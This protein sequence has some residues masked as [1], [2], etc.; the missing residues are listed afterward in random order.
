MPKTANGTGTHHYF[1][2]DDAFLAGSMD[3][4]EVRPSSRHKHSKTLLAAGCLDVPWRACSHHT[5]C[6]LH[7]LLPLLLRLHQRQLLLLP[8]YLG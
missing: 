4:F 7:L 1:C 8:C 6:T 2:V 5:A 3:G